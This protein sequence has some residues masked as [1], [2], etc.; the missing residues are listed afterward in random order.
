MEFREG[1]SDK[2][3]LN[4]VPA[5][6][7]N[8]YLHAR[9]EWGERYG[10]Y[11]ASARN[12]RVIGISALGVAAILG[13]DNWHLANKAQSVPYI[14]ERDQLGQVLYVGQATAASAASPLIIRAALPTWIQRARQIIT[15]PIAERQSIDAV[16]AFLAKGS[17]A[18]T[19]LTDWYGNRQPFVLGQTE[20]VSVQVTSA[21]PVGS[22]AHTWQVAWME[23]TTL[24][25][26]DH[27]PPV[28][29]VATIT[30]E[31]TFPKAD[32]PQSLAN[33]IGLEITHFNWTK[34]S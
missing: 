30:F 14:V 29:W 13:L 2:N 20:E 5:K 16:Y 7:D 31:Q 22:S 24:G 15:D 3:P 8:P 12:W 10:D 21:L 28:H 34:Q 25:D 1:M 11:V 4:E 32:T 19:T 9:A 17:P 6:A 23:T 27:T 26:G 18:Y 33:P